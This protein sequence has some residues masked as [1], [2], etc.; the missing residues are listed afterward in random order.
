ML[1]FNINDLFTGHFPFLIPLVRWG[2]SKTS[3]AYKFG[4]LATALRHLIKERRQQLSPPQ[5]V[6]MDH[7]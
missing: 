3:A 6:I 2:A 4:A 5:K 1:S 7:Y